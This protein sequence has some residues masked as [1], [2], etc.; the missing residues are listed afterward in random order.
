LSGRR[1]A[2]EPVGSR[3]GTALAGSVAK[4]DFDLGAEDEPIEGFA[5]APLVTAERARDLGCGHVLGAG[6]EQLAH[7]RRVAPGDVGDR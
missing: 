5:N 6:R 7:A 3:K 2:L 1:R 4:L